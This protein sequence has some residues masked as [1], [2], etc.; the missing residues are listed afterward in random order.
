MSAPSTVIG[1]LRV[2]NEELIIYETL[3]HLSIFVDKI[4]VFDDASTDKTAQICVNHPKVEGVIRESEWGMKEGYN[5]QGEQLQ[6]LLQLAQEEQPHWFIN[7]EAD[8]RFDEDFL[9]AYLKLLTQNK[10]DAVAFEIYDFYITKDDCD[11]EYIGDLASLRRFCGTEYRSSIL[12]FR[13]VREAYF[14]KGDYAQPYG[15]DEA[16]I[17][18]SQYKVKHYGKAISIEDFERKVRFY[19]TYFPRYRNKW[20]KRQGK[21]VHDTSDFD[22][23][24]AKLVTW[25]ALKTDST[26]RGPCIDSV[27]YE[28][29][30]FWRK[31]CKYL[32]KK[33][34]LF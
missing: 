8:L 3:N 17:L 18:K 15:F 12:L 22:Y 24:G 33:T 5:P 11:K 19:M 30:S 4:Y 2:R 20:M 1:L 29:T 34:N 23:L 27:G 25:D 16:K 14:P 9:F 28:S 31:V 32:Q 10:Y 26:L 13:N 21:A 7:L 6:R